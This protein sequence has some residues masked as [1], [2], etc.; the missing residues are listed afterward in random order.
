MGNEIG[1][2]SFDMELSVNPQSVTRDELYAK[3]WKEP[4]LR[5]AAYFDV[6]SS[7]LARVCS[8]LR[9][10]RPPRGHWAKLEFGKESPQPPLPEVQ[11][12]DVTV[13]QRG[14]MLS[15]PKPKLAS[16][17][18]PDAKKHLRIRSEPGRAANHDLVEDVKPFFL[19]A[20]GGGN[21][22]LRPTKRLLVDIMVSES[23]LDEALETANAIFQKFAEFGY[24]TM[25][26]TSQGIRRAEVDEREVPRKGHHHRTLWSPARPT[27]V[28]ID[29]V[30]IGLTLFEMTEEIDVVYVKGNYIPQRSLTPQQMHRYQGPLHW[31][32]KNDV[33]SGRLCLQAYCPNW[34]VAWSKQ[35]RETKP[36]QLR[37]Q[38]AQ[39]VHEL[40]RIA[41]A[42][43]KQVEEAESFA[44]SQRIAREEE[45][46][47]YW[48]EAERAKNAK[49]QADSRSDLLAAIAGWDEVRRI[50]DFFAAAETAIG[51]LAESERAVIGNRLGQAR[52]LVGCLEPLVALKNWKPPDER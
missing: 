12:G 22:L 36:R 39:I 37:S 5:V 31:S 1:P 19:K 26:V 42:L 13:W 7:Y 9:V 16:S 23:L 30:A 41:P 33:P 38:T 29:N 46:Q 18:K 27:A 24:R 49:L 6:S 4:M 3:V 14:H 47:R 35:W 2:S 50:H 17:A 44:E 48:I 28:F 32:T 34:K 10:P 15:S 40:E 25:L 51:E 45:Y 52:E 20:R 21:E 8:E 11:A 43:A